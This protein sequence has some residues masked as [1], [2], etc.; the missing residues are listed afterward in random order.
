MFSG[1]N[2]FVLSTSISFLSWW[3]NPPSYEYS[4]FC[5]PSHLLVFILAVST[6]WLLWIWLLWICVSMTLFEILFSVLLG[7]HLEMELQGHMVIF[8]LTFWGALRLFSIAAEQ[9]FVPTNN[10]WGFHFLLIL[11]NTCYFKIFIL[12]R[13][14]LGLWGA[15]SSWVLFAFP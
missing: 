15:I 12:M 14:I 3:D 6:F 13:A 4:T 7:V 11:A 5:L 10:A 2:R 8:C 1:F 9:F